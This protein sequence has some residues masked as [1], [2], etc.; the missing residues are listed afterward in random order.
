M[1]LVWVIGAP[2]STQ[3]ALERMLSVERTGVTYA[4][5]QADSLSQI[6]ETHLTNPGVVIL[7]DAFST[8]TRGFAG[9]KQL[10]ERGFKGP[11]FL[12]GEPANE[13]A[14]QAFATLGLSG[15]FPPF[16]RA[17]L[18]FVAGVVHS[19]V[20]YDGTVEI[21][22]FIQA[23][24]RSSSETIRSLADFN[25]FS[26]K[27]AAFVT[28]FGIEPNRLRKVLMAL[29]LPHV[30]TDSGAP[31][32][33]HAFQVH[34][35]MDPY[36]VV[37]ACPTFSRGANLE[38]VRA[39]YAGAL[40]AMRS[41]KPFAGAMFPE[42][43]HITKATENLVLLCG[44]SSSADPLTIDPIMLLTTLTFPPKD[45]AAP[46]PYFFSFVHVVPT[47]ELQ[48]S[49][50]EGAAADESAPHPAEVT[51]PL[52]PEEPAAV[53]AHEETAKGLLQ[54]EDLGDLL[55]EPKLV[56]DAPIV[57]GED[58]GFASNVLPF[59]APEDILAGTSAPTGADGAP[60]V[61]IMTGEPV[62]PAEG[63]SEADLSGPASELAQRLQAAL[64]EIA[65]LR[66]TCESMGQDIKRLMKERRTPTTDKE[67]RAVNEQL[68]ESVKQ[69]KLD[70][71]KALEMV[72]TREKQIELMKVQIETLKKEKAA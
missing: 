57:V 11:L 71:G 56:G 45:K 42:F 9:L 26:A 12:F 22:R 5:R 52:H 59:G 20:E 23:G 68:Q 60:A 2:P 40:S 46:V 19:S 28:R 47:A 41:D 4:V 37:L 54:T 49:E 35:G 38:N 70:K 27:L 58:S 34:Y 18:P 8:E 7:V 67:L 69:L 30:K 66:R 51:A 63:V 44:S 64:A 53:A 48:E 29:S 6:P 10:R 1:R 43:H 39:N 72:G 65:M 17:D 32:I 61:D 55:A 13:E 31:S 15:F 62:A 33:E 36:K 24:G 3:A 16:E 50:V 14:S 25:A 21:Q